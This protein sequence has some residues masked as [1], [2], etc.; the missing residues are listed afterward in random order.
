MA[1]D[2]APLAPSRQSFDNSQMGRRLSPGPLALRSL[3]QRALR[4]ARQLITNDLR[5]V[6]IQFCLQ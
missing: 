1:G 4:D 5:V 2:F 3:A 6:L